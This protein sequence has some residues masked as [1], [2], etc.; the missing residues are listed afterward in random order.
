M[1][2]LNNICFSCEA[3]KRIATYKYAQLQQLAKERAIQNEKYYAIYYDS[4][5]D[6]IKVGEEGTHGGITIEVFSKFA[7]P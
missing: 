4:D 2:A 6:D 5:D 7:R 3:K 1:E